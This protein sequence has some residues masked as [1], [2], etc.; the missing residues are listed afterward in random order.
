MKVL[1]ITGGIGS[2][3][4]TVSRMFEKFGAEVID[5]DEI[6]RAITKRNGAAYGEIVESFGGRILL[7][8]GE[9]DRKKLAGIVFTNKSKLML[10]NSITHKYV[11]AE[12]QRRIDDSLSEVIVLDVPLLFTSEFRIECDF[13]I[14]VVADVQERIRRV[15]RRDGILEEEILSRIENQISDDVL[16]EKADFIVE[17]NDMEA[18]LSAVEEIM[19]KIGIPL[20]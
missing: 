14:G 4:S 7:P 13:T 18:A 19:H 16:R 10:L 12:M 3:K 11:Y 20:I 9:I 8:D 6:S 15:K 5:A 17:N 2:G 1:G